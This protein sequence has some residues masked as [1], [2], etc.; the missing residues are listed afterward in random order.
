MLLSQHIR[1]VA[2]FDHRH[3]FLDPAPDPRASFAER[4]RLFRLPRSSWADYDARLI[5]KG[6]GVFPRTAKEIALS[7]EMKALTGL[8][9]DKA[10]PQELIRALL[11]AHVDLL[12]F[13]G[14]GTFI[15]ASTQA[16]IDVGDRANDALRVNGRDIRAS[17]VGEGANLGVTQLGRIE[18]ARIGGCRSNSRP[19]IWPSGTNVTVLM[20]RKM[21]SAMYW[22]GVPVPDRE[23]PFQTKFEDVASGNRR[24]SPP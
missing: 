10:T 18:Y 3:I 11:T 15:K 21:N 5:S 17:V 7:D 2:A 23:R 14:I 20:A 9:K 12:F 4:E 22:S 8:L 24:S 16:Q 19:I 13:G 1:L 6:G